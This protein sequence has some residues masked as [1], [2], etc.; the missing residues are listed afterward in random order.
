MAFTDLNVLR[1]CKAAPG[2]HQPPVAPARR[3]WSA[4]IWLIYSSHPYLRQPAGVFHRIAAA[5]CVVGLLQV[6][7]EADLAWGRGVM[8]ASLVLRHE[9][10]MLMSSRQAGLLGL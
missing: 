2:P 10:H 8:E 1:G 9:D 3:D 4:G 6:I 5:G 7:P